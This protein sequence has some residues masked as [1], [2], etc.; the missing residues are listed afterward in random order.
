MRTAQECRD[1]GF[2]ITDDKCCKNIKKSNGTPLVISKYTDQFRILKM[3]SNRERLQQ[4]MIVNPDTPQEFKE[5]RDIPVVKWFDLSDKD[6]K[7]MLNNHK[8]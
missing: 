6:Q 5:W 7:T 3:P 2:L 4:Q 8:V 1:C